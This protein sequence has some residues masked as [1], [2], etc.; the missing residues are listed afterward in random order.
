MKERIL[1]LNE[2]N[3]DKEVTK[4]E[5]VVLVDFWAPWC[6]PCKALAPI[7]QELSAESAGRFKVAKVNIDDCPQLASRQ[8]VMNIP[9]MILF[10]N[11]AEVDRLIG[12]LPKAGIL[13]RINQNIK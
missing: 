8:E 5:A 12:L 6:G 10:K 3:F 4:S 2:Q 7:I 13:A 11:G 1:E 9:T